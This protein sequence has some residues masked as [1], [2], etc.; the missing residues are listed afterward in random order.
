M[1][2]KEEKKKAKKEKKRQIA[3]AAVYNSKVV[4]KT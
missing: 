4:P 1:C 3:Y 2:S